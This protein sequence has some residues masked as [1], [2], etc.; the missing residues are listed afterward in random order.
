MD[1]LGYGSDS[2]VVRTGVTVLPGAGALYLNTPSKSTN[3]GILS[4]RYYLAAVG[5]NQD[6]S[7]P[8]LDGPWYGLG[9]SGI[10]GFTDK[11]C[12]AGYY[13]CALRSAYGSI[14]LD[15]GGNVG[16]GT[17]NPGSILTISGTTYPI[18]AANA[19]SY[20]NYGQLSI[21]SPTPPSSA[22]GAIGYTKIGFDHSVGNWGASFI[23]SVIPNTQNPPLLLQPGEEGNV[24][25][26]TT[27][28][29]ARLHVNGNIISSTSTVSLS[30]TPTN[31]HLIQDNS[32]G[33]III[34]GGN[35][36]YLGWFE[37][38]G[39]VT[40]A[41]VFPL[42]SQ[43][44]SNTLTVTITFAGTQPYISASTTSTV[45]GV[46]VRTLLI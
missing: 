19:A 41:A 24:G 7:G 36:K 5:D 3:S 9:W 2:Q 44:A 42:A 14:I 27:N 28:P 4:N 20:P 33:F 29:G 32:S 8:N 21:S 34:K 37:W 13:G 6:E 46:N 1:L 23:K 43:N 11:P 31:I 39:G 16:I 22:A 18:T 25:I 10:P 15:Y 12:L 45:G 26:G 17:T 40:T 30:S 38:W 35:F